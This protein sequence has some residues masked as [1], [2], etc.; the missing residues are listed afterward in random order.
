V[1]ELDR[2]GQVVPRGDHVG[3]EQPV[4]LH[5]RSAA[6]GNIRCAITWSGTRLRNT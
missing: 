5:D 1:E 2:P 3:V 6:N 4:A